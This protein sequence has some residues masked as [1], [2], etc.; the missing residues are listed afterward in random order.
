MLRGRDQD[1]DD[2]MSSH[3]YEPEAT[4]EEAQLV[5]RAIPNFNDN[6]SNIAEETAADVVQGVS[7]RLP[8]GD[9]VDWVNA[10]TACSPPP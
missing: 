2:L 5:N 10:P 6:M 7:S 9:N 3:S 4:P 1:I 8:F